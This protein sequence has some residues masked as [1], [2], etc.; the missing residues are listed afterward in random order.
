M[1]ESVATVVVGSVV[2][3]AGA[4]VVVA[5]P[6]KIQSLHRVVPVKHTGPVS[7]LILPVPPGP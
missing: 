7:C 3:V 2:V 4:V 6:L 1:V 5:D